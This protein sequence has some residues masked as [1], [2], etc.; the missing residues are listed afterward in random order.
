MRLLGECALVRA[1]YT[2]RG[3]LKHGHTGDTQ[4]IQFAD[5]SR[6]NPFR[7][8]TLARA[9]LNKMNKRYLL[10]DGDIVLRSRGIDNYAMLVTTPPERMICIA[11][12]LYLRVVDRTK[13]LPEYL[14]WFLNLS[15]VQSIFSEYALFDKCYTR[16]ICARDVANL[17]MPLPAIEHQRDIVEY[18]KQE[19]ESYVKLEE[20][21]K[22]RLLR[23]EKWLLHELQNM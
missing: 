14:H 4:I 9:D 11:P 13:L 22:A 6:A 12:L 21:N 10:C 1:G 3:S 5:I 20:I 19:A 18:Y 8:D 17:L 23:V 15:Q 7:T 2:Y 16:Y